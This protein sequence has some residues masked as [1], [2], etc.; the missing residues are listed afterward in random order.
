VYRHENDTVA[1]NNINRNT[2]IDASDR[3]KRRIISCSSTAKARRRLILCVAINR[4]APSKPWMTTAEPRTRSSSLMP[5]MHWPINHTQSTH[6]MCS[7]IHIAASI[8]PNGKGSEQGERTSAAHNI[9]RTLFVSVSANT[10]AARRCSS[11]CGTA[12]IAGGAF[13]A[14]PN[15]PPGLDNRTRKQIP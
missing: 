15:L 14:G 8:V 13:F 2:A 5:K 4:A 6:D 1:G 11:D 10:A 9:M 3:S 7:T 12:T